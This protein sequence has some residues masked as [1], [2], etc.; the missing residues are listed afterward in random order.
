[1]LVNRQEIVHEDEPVITELLVQKSD[2]VQDPL[3]WF[4]T[5]FSLPKGRG[6]AERAGKRASS[7][8]LNVDKSVRYL[9]RDR[10]SVPVEPDTAIERCPHG[11]KVAQ[12]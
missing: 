6:C 9:F 3:D 12:V 1:M 5:I 11:G 2:F 7:S 8:R 4:D 10:L